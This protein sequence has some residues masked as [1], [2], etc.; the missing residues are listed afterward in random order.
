MYLE[1]EILNFA[2]SEIFKQTRRRNSYQ[3]TM[4]AIEREL[5]ESEDYYQIL[6]IRGS[7]EVILSLSAWLALLN[8]WMAWR[9]MLELNRTKSNNV[10]LA[11]DVSS[12]L[13]RMAA[14]LFASLPFIAGTAAAISLCCDEYNGY[15][16]W[17][18][19]RV[20]TWWK[21]LCYKDL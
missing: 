7:K 17:V 14:I 9:A 1:E 21:F 13:G 2:N 12:N 11:A 15:F 6:D 10:W 19:L 20:L 16:I 3:N 8:F 4:A 5:S 18:C